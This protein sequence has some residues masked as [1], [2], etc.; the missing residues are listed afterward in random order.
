MHAKSCSLSS[1]PR[2]GKTLPAPQMLFH[3]PPLWILLP[4][5]LDEGKPYRPQLVA[6]SGCREGKETGKNFLE[7]GGSALHPYP[8]SRLLLKSCFCICRSLLA[9]LLSR[10]DAADCMAA[11]FL[12][13]FG[14]RNIFKLECPMGIPLYRE[15][16]EESA[17]WEQKQIFMYKLHLLNSLSWLTSFFLLLRG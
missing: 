9:P 17:T 13:S 8:E 3:C 15:T 16:L 11:R 14:N 7:G 5:Q 1:I 12:K 10:S 4:W 2:L 6:K